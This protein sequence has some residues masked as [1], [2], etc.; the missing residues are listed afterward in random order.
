[1]I[2]PGRKYSPVVV[3]ILDGW[4][5]TNSVHGNAIIA[6]DKPET[7]K[8]SLHYP[9]M[10]LQASGIGVGLP[11]NEP[12]NSEVGHTTIGSGFIVYQ[13][14]P[15]IDM[16]IQN[17]T[18]NKNE[19]F[20]AAMDRALQSDKKLHLVGL[21]SD[22][23]VHSHID[24]LFVLLDMAAERGLQKVFV[25]V[26]TDGRDTLPNKGVVFVERLIQKMKE[27]GVGRIATLGGR[28]Y[29]MDRNNNWDRIAK[30]YNCMTRGEGRCQNDPLKAI[31]ESY[32]KN[33]TDEFIEP[34]CFVDGDN[35]PQGLVEAGD[36][37]IFFNY[38]EDRMRQITRAFA[39]A[40]FQEFDRGAQ[41]QDL[42]MVSMIEYEPGM[43]I[44]IAFGL[45]KIENPLG[46][47]L[48][49][50]G[51]KQLR[52][53]ETEKYAHVTY[54]FNGGNEQEYPNESRIMVPSPNVKTY[55]EKPEMSAYEVTRRLIGEIENDSFDFIVINF[56]NP[57]MVGHTGNFE[58]AVEA[59][60][61]VDK[62]VGK[63]VRSVLKKNGVLLITADHGNCENMIDERTGEVLTDHTNNPVPFWLVGRDFFTSKS[64]QEI[65]ISQSRIGG[66]LVDI[67]PTVLQLFNL[68]KPPEMTGISLL[69][70]L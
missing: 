42:Y 33:V 15:R 60:E 11:W 18:F 30:A 55:D 24:H 14:L 17:N 45:Q 8:L 40:D 4:G 23:A 12:G 47:V 7:D 29:G 61:C 5:I 35:P 67:A 2:S 69:D 32:K 19:H 37:I 57:D 70:M 27:S 28:Y 41:I 66:M 43:P 62:C 63:V 26:I 38:R 59:V 6:A 21:L 52:I 51:L 31:E 39:L 36:S 46:K 56:A 50:A 1:M 49:E 3:M 58:A 68:S 53:A 10:T 34:V 65:T 48:S 64:I 16:A 44:D 54:F 25:H 22:G 13:N 9:Y 20:L